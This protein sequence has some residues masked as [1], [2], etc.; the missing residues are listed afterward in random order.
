MEKIP[1]V[2]ALVRDRRGRLLLTRRPAGKPRAGLWE[3]PGGKVKPGE[4]LAE[5][6]RR[7]LK[8]ELGL[9]ASVGRELAR[10]TYAY[11]DLTIE[12]I[13]LEAFV[14]GV[15]KALEGQKWDWFEPSEVEAVSLAPADQILWQ[16]LKE[17]LG[18]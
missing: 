8:E 2:A 6:L 17:K 4:D 13:L 9:E 7:E 10:T 16:D 3:F 14:R 1:V 15:P 12:L 5:A 11:P 18:K